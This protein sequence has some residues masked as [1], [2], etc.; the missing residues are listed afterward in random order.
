MVTLKQLCV[1]LKS[2]F[3]LFFRLNEQAQANKYDNFF[4]LKKSRTVEIYL[5]F[6][7]NTHTFYK[8]FVTVNDYFLSNTWYVQGVIHL[9]VWGEVGVVIE[10]ISYVYTFKPDTMTEL[11]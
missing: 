5:L 10:D 2:L 11:E 9:K 7:L 6:L 3:E 4:K 8:K 1:S